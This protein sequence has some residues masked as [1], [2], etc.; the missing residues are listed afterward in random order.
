MKSSPLF[1]KIL[2]TRFHL[3]PRNFFLLLSIVVG[4]VA[5]LA[6]VALKQATHGLDTLLEVHKKGINYWL[7]IFPVIGIFLATVYTWV[8]QKGKLGRGISNVVNN[9]YHKSSYMEKDKM[10]SHII[11]SSLTV[12]FGGSMGLEAPIVVTGSAFG[13]NIA[14]LFNLDYKD[15][16]LLLACG[17]AAG[18]SAIFGAPIAGVLFA[19]EVLLGEFS[20]VNF[21]PLLISSAM[22]SVVSQLL[23]SSGQQIFYLRTPG[24]DVHALPFYIIMSVML[25]FYSVYI[26][27]GIAFSEKLLSPLKNPYKR[28]IVGGLVLGILI[29]LFPPLYGEGYHTVQ[30]LLDTDYTSLFN[31]SIF[32]RLGNDYSA[33][34]LLFFTLGVLFIKVVAAQLTVSSGG[35]GGFFAPSLFMG[36]MAGFFFVYSINYFNICKI[37]GIEKLNEPNFIAVAMAGLMSGVMHTPLTAIFLIAEATGGY[38]LLVPLMVVSSFSFLISKYFV[39]HSIYVKH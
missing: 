21:V 6:A 4:I 31:G 11:T 35:N 15:R 24:W 19:I 33:L 14:A 26:M 32:S 23:Y 3:S 38:S 18:I 39:P 17:A 22:A 9:I 30:H 34:V 27:R 29:F 37:L 36:S 10:Y 25:G 20:T 28:A 2:S 13:S 7:L 1:Q 16:T 12:G 5:G 8:V